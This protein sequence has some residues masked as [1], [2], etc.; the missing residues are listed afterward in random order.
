ML[1]VNRFTGRFA[2]GVGSGIYEYRGQ[3]CLEQHS[4]CLVLAMVQ[5]LGLV[6]G[7]SSWLSGYR[8]C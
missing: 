3:L 4:L 7:V 2:T 5:I 1:G 8:L 6:R